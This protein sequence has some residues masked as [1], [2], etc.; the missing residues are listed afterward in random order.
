VSE[1]PTTAGWHPHPDHP[2]K[3]AYFNGK[4]WSAVL[5]DTMPGDGPPP[6]SSPRLVSSSGPTEA[7]EAGESPLTIGLCALFCGVFL[8]GLLFY[9]GMK[10]ESAPLIT[11]GVVVVGLT[12]VIAQ[13]GLTAY[14]V[15]W[16]MRYYH[17]RHRG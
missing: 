9:F 6:G 15:Y 5:R 12:T 4:V 8:G 7:G 3:F 13:V 2:G 1:R 14:A 10:D 17:Q 16:G 11:L